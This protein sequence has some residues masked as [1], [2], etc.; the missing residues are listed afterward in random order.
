MTKDFKLGDYVMN[1]QD[2][3]IYFIY[4]IFESY[5]GSM[6]YVLSSVDDPDMPLLFVAKE[7]ITLY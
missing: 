2:G 1:H 3:H 4:N 5:T 6:T 7:D